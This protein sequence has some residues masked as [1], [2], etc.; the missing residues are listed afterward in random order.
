MKIKAEH[1]DC[2]FFCPLGNKRWFQ[3]SGIDQVTE[4]DWWE[5]RDISLTSKESVISERAITASANSTAMHNTIK[6]Q[7][8]C[9]PCQ[10]TSARTGFDK[11]LTLWAS[12]SIESGQ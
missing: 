5:L 8:G 12:W 11:G 9:L 4:L 3:K 2:H 10:H 1:P 6:A 7:V